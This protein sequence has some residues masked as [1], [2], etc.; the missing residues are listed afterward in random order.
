MGVCSLSL[1]GFCGVGKQYDW[2]TSSVF[3][4]FHKA[5]YIMISV[6]MIVIQKVPQ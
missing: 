5:N 3:D 2:L 1:P 4:V 6:V